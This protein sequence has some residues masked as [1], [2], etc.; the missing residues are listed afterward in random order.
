MNLWET[1]TSAELSDCSR[2]SNA[3]PTAAKCEDNSRSLS[4]I[5]SSPGIGGSSGP[6]GFGPAPAF[7]PLG[8]L[9]VHSALRPHGPQVIGSHT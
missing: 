8:F 7:R 6:G 5:G 3:E 1:R 9:P 4:A 2:I